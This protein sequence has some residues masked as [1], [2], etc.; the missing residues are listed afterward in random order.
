MYKVGSPLWN[1]AMRIY[2]DL[3]SVS[4]LA[5]YRL[6]KMDCNCRLM[7]RSALSAYVLVPIQQWWRR[8][9]LSSVIHVLFT[10]SLR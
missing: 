2:V 9:A 5:F 6:V 4:F 8:P 3:I 10:M 7:A 1:Q